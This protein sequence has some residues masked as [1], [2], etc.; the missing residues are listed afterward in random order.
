[1]ARVELP[2]SRLKARKRAK[3]VR[4]ALLCAVALALLLGGLVALARASFLRITGVVVSG[5]SSVATSSVADAVNAHL[6]G[7]W[8]WVIPKNN[9]FLY[10]KEDIREALVR[11][12]PQWKTVD[13]HAV[14]FHT[15]A[16]SATERE[17]AALWCASVATTTPAAEVAAGC[18][19]MDEDGV[20]Y[21]RASSASTTTTFVSYSGGK[22]GA[23][24]WQYLSRDDFRALAALAAALSE[25]EPADSVRQVVVDDD[26]D[27]L[28]YFQ[29]DFLLLFTLRDESGDVFERFTLALKSDPFHGKTLGNFEYLDLRFGDKLYYKAK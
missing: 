11:A 29:N 9:I 15:V 20:V 7:S 18:Y 5:T 3:R 17:P 16:V 21:A 24:P 2:Q 4:I 22:P 10:P 6:V 12:Y 8:L 1:M 27:A 26:G 14:D 23:V 25:V 19:T 13:V 28:A